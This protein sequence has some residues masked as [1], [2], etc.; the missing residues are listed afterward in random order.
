MKTYLV[1]A[2]VVLSTL[3][4]IVSCT[5]FSDANPTP[6]SRIVTP[7]ITP[8][9][10][11]SPNL[12]PPPLFQGR[13]ILFIEEEGIG[14]LDLTNADQTEYVTLSNEHS[15]YIFNFSYA[16]SPDQRSFAFAVEHHSETGKPAIIIINLDTYEVSTINFLD[17][18]DEDLSR[19]LPGWVN[20]S[21]DSRKLTYIYRQTLFVYDIDSKATIPVYQ[22]ASENYYTYLGINGTPMPL[23]GQ[24]VGEIH[25]ELW[26]ADWITNDCI[27][28][29]SFEGSMPETITIRDDGQIRELEPNTTTLACYQPEN[30]VSRTSENFWLADVIDDGAGNYLI[31]STYGYGGEESFITQPFSDFL[32]LDLR[33]LPELIAS[34]DQMSRYVIREGMLIAYEATY[35]EDLYLLT[36]TVNSVDVVS[37][38][39]ETFAPVDRNSY[40]VPQSWGSVQEYQPLL[41][42]DEDGLN[43]STVLFAAGEDTIEICIGDLESGSFEPLWAVDRPLVFIVGI[44]P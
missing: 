44:L 23:P 11:P 26:H 21:P 31:L 5:P 13:V 3:I 40:I 7:A 34:D 30:T 9:I 42:I 12:V 20:W 1:I 8:T 28:F 33:S 38:D 16:L 19:D 10:T 41:Q 32:E 35:S 24:I 14:I 15:I 29:R 37:V 2:I 18:D 4:N 6:Q 43:L 17:F 22:G 25:G 27:M 39:L 36:R